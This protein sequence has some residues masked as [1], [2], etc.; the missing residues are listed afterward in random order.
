MVTVTYHALESDQRVLVRHPFTQFV[1]RPMW[2]R[3]HDDHRIFLSY[4][5]P[6]KQSLAPGSV[7]HRP[8]VLVEHFEPLDR[9]VRFPPVRLDA[10]E[11][12]VQVRLVAQMVGPPMCHQRDL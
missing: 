4:V 11:R 6:R 10:L 3:L 12:R 1:F 7:V 8:E 9:F 2:S 5:M